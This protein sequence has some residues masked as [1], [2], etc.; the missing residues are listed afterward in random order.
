VWIP[1]EYQ[2]DL[3]RHSNFA[4]SQSKGIYSGE[5]E[6]VRE[7]WKRGLRRKRKKIKIDESVI[8]LKMKF[9]LASRLIV[10]LKQQQR[11]KIHFN[12]LSLTRH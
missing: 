10:V 1:G 9:T 11:R 6:K 12:G 4:I 8:H 3:K 7:E 5:S 2:C